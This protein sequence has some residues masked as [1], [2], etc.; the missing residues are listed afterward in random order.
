MRNTVA[1][2]ALVTVSA[3][4]AA[5]A[6]EPRALLYPSIVRGEGNLLAQAEWSG[7]T[8]TDAHR[9]IRFT[10]DRGGPFSADDPCYVA[11]TEAALPAYWRTIAKIQP[12]RRYLV[13]A[14]TRF[15]NA[16]ILFWN[17][18]TDAETGHLAQQRLY[19]FGGFN[20]F[21]KPY[22]SENT[23][24]K[25]CGDVRQWR[26]FYRVIE[27]PHAL[28]GDSLCIANGLFLTSGEMRFANPFLVDVTDVRNCL[29]TVDVADGRG[30][31]KLEVLHAG[32]RDLVWEKSFSPAVKAYKAELPPEIDALRGQSGGN[33]IYG[34]VLR[35]VYANGDENFVSAPC[36]G[37]FRVR[38]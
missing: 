25:I 11:S 1:F 36:E 9:G 18:G 3:L 32:I 21:L 28:K 7:K 29:L 33:A 38:E 35:V 4:F 15:E 8:E 27:F 31:S 12:R 30:I 22:F 23:L 10:T 37:V 2:G 6:D 34:N 17:Y 24:S 13:G 14:W 19:F 26:V 16:R 5:R 20:N